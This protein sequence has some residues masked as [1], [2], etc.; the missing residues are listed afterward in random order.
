MIKELKKL[1]D[2]KKVCVFGNAE[3]VLNKKRNIDSYDVIIR[4]NYGYPRHEVYEQIGTR[5]DVWFFGG[6]GKDGIWGKDVEDI[7][8]PKLK[9]NS[10]KVFLVRVG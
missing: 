3:S 6:G 4:M 1:I 10:F 5:T 8:N 9:K 2:K 7:F